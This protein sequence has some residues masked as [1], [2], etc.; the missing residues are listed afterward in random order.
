MFDVVVSVRSTYDVI[1]RD[2][3]S[4]PYPDEEMA[5]EAA[6][7]LAAELVDDIDDYDVTWSWG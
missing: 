4:I 6:W 3:V 2:T 7:D 5:E 1:A